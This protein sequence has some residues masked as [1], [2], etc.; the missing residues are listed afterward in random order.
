MLSASVDRALVNAAAEVV[1]LSDHGKLG[2]DTMFQTVPSEAI[3]HLVTDEQSTLAEP[4]ARELDALADRGVQ[5]HIAPLTPAA[6]YPSTP[7]DAPRRPAG[8]P[9][10]RRGPVPVVS[11]RR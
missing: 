3:T 10:Q 9:G 11:G 5:V 6:A 4:S 8:F 7:S 2:N 1:V